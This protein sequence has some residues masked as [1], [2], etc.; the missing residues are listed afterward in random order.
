MLH[1]ALQQLLLLLLLGCLSTR[2]GSGESESVKKYHS[3]E[4]RIAF[5]PS[6]KSALDRGRTVL[7]YVPPSYFADWDER[8]KRMHK[9][10]DR[11]D[12]LFPAYLGEPVS[13]ID[14]GAL[15]SLGG[16]QFMRLPVKPPITI[17]LIF[18]NIYVHLFPI[19]Y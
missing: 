3:P 18:V 6:L 9:E 7:V 10:H 13:V 2:S 5:P 11:G 1:D 8:F 17:F 15:Q 14:S 12:K 4:S 19:D 16:N